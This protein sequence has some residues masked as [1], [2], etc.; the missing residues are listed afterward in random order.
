MNEH[1]VSASLDDV[2]TLVGFFVEPDRAPTLVAASF[3]V[4]FL[5]IGVGDD[6]LDSAV[7]QQLPDRSGR[8]CL[9]AQRRYRCRSRSPAAHPWD[10]QCFEQVGKHRGVAALA[11][12]DD[13]DQRTHFRIAQ[14][15]DPGR[16]TTPRPANRM[17]RGFAVKI[18]VI[19]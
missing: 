13:D 6:R 16:Q 18:R 14:A 11:G 9:I 7:A 4:P 10:L 12:R 3:A 5:V 15:M 8:I 19:R 2:A 1:S 17:V